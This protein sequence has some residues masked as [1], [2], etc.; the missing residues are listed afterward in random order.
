MSTPEEPNGS[1]RRRAPLDP[2]AEVDRDAELVEQASRGLQTEREGSASAFV[3][4]HHSPPQCGSGMN[5]R[6]LPFSILI[7]ISL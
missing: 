6:R 4:P 2:R 7:D 5:D 3:V 1:T